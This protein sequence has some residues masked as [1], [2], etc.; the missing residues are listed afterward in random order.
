MIN[1]VFANTIVSDSYVSRFLFYLPLHLDCK[2]K[3]INDGLVQTDVWN[4]KTEGILGTK[5]IMRGIRR[6]VERPLTLQCLHIAIPSLFGYPQR[7]TDGRNGTMW[8]IFDFFQK[9]ENDLFPFFF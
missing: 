7:L 1:V 9:L 8:M 5:F 2:L 3:L 6:F 4:P